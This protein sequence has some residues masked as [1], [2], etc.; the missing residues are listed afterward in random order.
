MKEQELSANVE[1]V[2]QTTLIMADSLQA[3]KVK[4]CAANLYVFFFSLY[5]YFYIFSL[6]VHPDNYYPVLFLWIS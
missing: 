1:L 2:Y 5:V 6:F 3:I 4:E